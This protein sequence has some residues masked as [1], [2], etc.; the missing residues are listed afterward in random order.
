MVG[1]PQEKNNI[2]Y[3]VVI[4]LYVCLVVH[5]IASLVSPFSTS[6]HLSQQ[7][8]RHQGGKRL[9][10]S[11]SVCLRRSL[12]NCERYEKQAGGKQTEF[13]PCIQIA[14]NETKSRNV[15]PL[16]VLL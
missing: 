6:L 3:L 10:L 2:L 14:Q 4:P 13:I 7:L 8:Y 1:I 5:V 9:H 16:W 15:L 12:L 11:I